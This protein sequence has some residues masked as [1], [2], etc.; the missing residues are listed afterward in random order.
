MY[1]FQYTVVYF[2][3]GYLSVCWGFFIHIHLLPTI[4][5]LSPNTEMAEEIKCITA[6]IAYSYDLS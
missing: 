1:T 3:N 6:K 4:K 2:R 5:Q